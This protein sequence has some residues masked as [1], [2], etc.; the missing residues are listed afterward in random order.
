LI[1]HAG[2]VKWAR[3]VLLTLPVLLCPPAWAQE[4]PSRPVTIVVPYAGGATPDL[5]ARLI[6][7]RLAQNLKRPVIVENRPGANGN[8]GAALVA[9]SAPDGYTLL[10]ADTALVTINPYV[11]RRLPFNAEHDLVLVAGLVES[12]QRLL[13]NAELAVASLPELIEF[14]RTADPPLTYAST[15]IGS[16]FHLTMERLK[17]MAGIAL[18]H[19]P[20]RGG[21]QA[22]TAAASG[23][24]AVV[25]AGSSADP[26]LRTGKLR[27]LAVTSAQRARAQPNLPALSE[28]FPGLQMSIWQGLFAPAGTPGP[29]LER[30]ELEI[31]RVLELPEVKARLESGI[32]LHPMGL[33]RLQFAERIRQDR[34]RNRAMV[35][36][37]GLSVE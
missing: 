29:V 3:A 12:S 8:I 21:V 25:L 31:A 17:R 11:Y 28:Y 18:L 36:Q 23:E 30:L 15:G 4:Y 13:V 5:A 22:A 2:M 26:F 20:Y 14:A 9:R 1:Y 24:V 10:L 35:D 16:P 6:A 32:D 33:T 27:A 19:V 7:E 34:E 37:L